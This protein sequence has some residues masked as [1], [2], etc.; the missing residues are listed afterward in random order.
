MT[1]I[2]L[3]IDALEICRFALEPYDDVKPR[4]WASDREN[5]KR[6][7]KTAK[8]T[9]AVLQSQPANLSEAL[10]C[11]IEHLEGE[12]KG[13][14]VVSYDVFNALYDAAKPAPVVDGMPD[15]TVLAHAL[16]AGF[17]LST[18][19]GQGANKLMPISD[20]K[21][22]IRFAELIRADLVKEGAE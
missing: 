17:A 7:H 21:T 20:S 10:N 22:L 1:A 5:L 12:H 2:N 6:A 11:T 15:N 18:A 14:V 4:N 3:A 9:L 19:Y 13:K 8:T 16:E